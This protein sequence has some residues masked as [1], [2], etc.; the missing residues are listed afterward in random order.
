MVKWNGKAGGLNRGLEG[1]AGQSPVYMCLCVCVS[2][3]VCVCVCVSVRKKENGGR[4][5]E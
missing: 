1:G 5:R 3:C 4:E 2:V